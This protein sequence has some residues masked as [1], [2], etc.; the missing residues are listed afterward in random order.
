L[1][2]VSLLEDVSALE[3]EL[4]AQL[5]GG[6]NAAKLQPIVWGEVG[7]RDYLPQW[8]QLVQLNAAG[9]KGITPESLSQVATDLKA[10]GKTLRDLSGAMPGDE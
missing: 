1:P 4:M 5:A 2:A 7:S 3:R 6:D 8:T 10:V 9:L